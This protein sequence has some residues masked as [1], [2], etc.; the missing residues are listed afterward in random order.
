MFNLKKLLIYIILIAAVVHMS[1]FNSKIFAKDVTKSTASDAEKYKFGDVVE[2]GRY[3]D[4]NEKNEVEKLP[5]KWKVLDRIDNFYLLITRD[6]IKTM[7]YNHSWVPTNWRDSDIRFWL[8]YDFYD[9]A[10]NDEEKKRIKR[11]IIEN[12]GNYQ[13]HLKNSFQTFDHVFLLSI[14]EAKKY[15]KKSSEYMSLELSL[16]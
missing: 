9:I 12:V 15:Y 4:L 8:N 5:I 14:E 2:F 7:P 16:L 1:F 6:I 10:F 11:I 13:Y 3:Y